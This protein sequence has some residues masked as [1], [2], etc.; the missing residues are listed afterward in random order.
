[1]CVAGQ[2]K[3]NAE[4]IQATSRVGRKFPGLIVTL[5]N[6]YKP[7]DLSVYENFTG[8]HSQMGRYVEGNSVTP[9]SAR[10]R[11]RVLHSIIISLIRLHIERMS[12]NKSAAEITTITDDEIAEL[13]KT[14]LQRI[15]NV[16]PDA[17]DGTEME[18]DRIIDFWKEQAKDGLLSYTIPFLK[19]EQKRLMAVYGD[20][21]VNEG[22]L[23]TLNSMRDVE[24][25]STMYLWD[26]KEEEN[27]D[28]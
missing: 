5:D 21:F 26:E 9:F 23:E 13:K 28:K 19:E 8:F 24:A 7:R 18:I 2:P 20:D 27:S 1:M 11:D 14:I 10:A 6:P 12:A 17:C 15:N 16:E 25:S 22:E 3:Q 4:F